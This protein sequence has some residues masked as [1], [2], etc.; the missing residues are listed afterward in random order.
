MADFPMEYDPCVC[1]FDSKLKIEVRLISQA[2][3]KLTGVTTGTLMST[4]SSTGATSTSST[5]DD[6]V[7]M[8]KKTNGVITAGQSTY[9]TL[10][11]YASALTGKLNAQGAKSSVAD[12]NAK[13]NAVQQLTA[14]I[15]S[16]SFLSAGLNAVP[17]IGTAV[18]IMD[19]FFGG[20]KDAGTQ[21]VSIQP[22]AIEMTTQ[23]TGTMSATAL[24]EAITFN[25][26]GTRT[27]TT[28]EE[29]PYYNEAMGVLS[30][31]R[32][33]V[34]EV[35]QSGY[36]DTDGR[37]RRLYQ[38]RVPAPIQYLINPASG[39][40]VQ[41][42][43]VALLQEGRKYPVVFPAGSTAWHYEGMSS[44]TTHVLRTDYLDANC[45][46]NNILELDISGNNIQDP[47]SS[48]FVPTRNTNPGSLYPIYLKFML[49]LRRRNTTATTQNVLLVLKFPVMVQEV[50]SFDELL[51]RS[52]GV[53]PQVD[54]ATVQSFCGS[55]TYTNAMNL[56]SGPGKLSAAPNTP[57]SA[58]PVIAD[59]QVYPNPA[60][61]V[62]TIRFSGVSAGRVSAYLT[63][64]VGRRVV[65]IMR[66]EEVMNGEQLK[67][68]STSA[69]APG[70]YQCVIET[71]GG[72]RITSRLSV[73]H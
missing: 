21:A 33:P 68:F 42:F 59:V 36:V 18:S 27:I 54:I 53:L 26:P 10:N 41:D 16:N 66:D 43:Q 7:N 70:L 67:A 72:A 30:V 32:K 37:N 48:E 52:C 15:G 60:S 65:T 40:E 57:A 62:A 47:A 35:K 50:T 24:Y 9:K 6:A 69:L 1:Q 34:V 3:I 51:P 46:S 12:A 31:L 39:L 55:A 13:K 22:M 61:E 17:Y 44:A 56:R 28:P 29:Y 2:D 19:S 49:N 8:F 71:S 45:L 11:S 58:V 23:M 20:G 38:Y 73:A 63:D 5:F 4:N 64:M 25:N 14:A